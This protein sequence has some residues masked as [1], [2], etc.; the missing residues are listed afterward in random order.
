M[1][2]EDMITS[3]LGQEMVQ[4]WSWSQEDFEFLS[5][6]MEKYS[7]ALEE[8]RRVRGPRSVR[9]RRELVFRFGG[10]EDAVEA[11]AYEERTWQRECLGQTR[12]RIPDQVR[13]AILVAS[14]FPP[15]PLGED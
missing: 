2:V 15:Q 3:P 10:S 14:Y 4:K 1:K 8:D 5:G 7:L 6:Y 13:D 11:W 9:V 12:Q